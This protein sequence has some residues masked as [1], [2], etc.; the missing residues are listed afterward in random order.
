MTAKALGGYEVTSA[1][2][3]WQVNF[4][5]PWLHCDRVLGDF[6]KKTQSAPEH[7]KSFFPSATQRTSV[8]E[9]KGTTLDFALSLCGQRLCQ[10]AGGNGGGE[11]H[12][13]QAAKEMDENVVPSD[14]LCIIFA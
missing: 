14:C 11:S 12:L 9:A 5:C 10:P 1:E 4:Q 6:L 13:F 3:K 8:S 7:K 2:R